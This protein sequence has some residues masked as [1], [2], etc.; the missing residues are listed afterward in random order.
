MDGKTDAAIT[1][2]AASIKLILAEIITLPPL[3]YPSE[4]RMAP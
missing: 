2:S 1:I 3:D 4:C